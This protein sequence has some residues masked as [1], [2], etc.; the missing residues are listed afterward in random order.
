MKTKSE[1]RKRQ[2]R[3]LSLTGFSKRTDWQFQKNSL[4]IAF[5]RLKKSKI[6]VTDLTASDPTRCSFNYLKPA[7][8][9]SFS[10]PKNLRYQPN[11]TGLFETRKS[12]AQ[13][14]KKNKINIKPNQIILTASTSEA[15]S[16][17]FRLL[18]EPGDEVLCP[19]PSYPL[20]NFLAQLNDVQL[21]HY[22]LIYDGGWEIDL[23]SLK[24]TYGP[25]TKAIILVNPNNPTGSYAKKQEL[26][27]IVD[28]ARTH[29]IALIS[30]EVFSDFYFDGHKKSV[31]SLAATSPYL[32]FTLNGIS[33]TIGLPQ[34]KLAWIAVNGESSILNSALERL[35]IIADTYLSVNTPVQNALP[36]WLKLKPKI[37]SEIRTRLNKNRKFLQNSIENH[38]CSLLE[39]DGGWYAILRLPQLKTEEEWCL[40]FL[41]KDR[42]FVHPGYFFDFEKEA[43]IIVSLLPPVKTFQEGIHKVLKRTVLEAKSQN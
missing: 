1:L 19:R 35:E 5:E 8:L 23:E 40:E 18:A 11:P 10:N 3:F 9:R 6:P 24:R 36:A 4:A 42:V 39:S 29:K 30:D 20:F 37:Q 38:S 27:E 15:Y 26:R 17:L 31:T 41:E 22:S 43:Y 32:G 16:F 2:S 13:N 7:L 33:K 25:K 34:M 28:F 14:Y 12:I 21:R